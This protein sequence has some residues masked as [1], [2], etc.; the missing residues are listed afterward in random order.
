MLHEH[1]HGRV[2]VVGLRAGERLVERGA[3][4]IDVGAEVDRLALALL[5]GH[6]GRGAQDLPGH[7]HAHVGQR[8]AG[9]AEVRDLHDALLG[10]HEVG[11]LDVAVDHAL[12]RGLREPLGRLDD[13]VQRLGLGEG[14]PLG[15]EFLQGG[16][17]DELH[18]DEVEAL[19]LAGVV[20]QD[21]VGVAQE[22]RDPCLDEEALGEGGF[23]LEEV[24]GEH[25]DGRLPAELQVDAA[26]DG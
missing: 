24:L 4:G 14:A 7:G 10:D 2:A 26:V 22:S 25:L 3:E 8:V 16:A 17:A 12:L 9:E 18:G 1:G 6:V 15:D 13:V 21:D 11:G 23:V 19:L 20:D 5:R